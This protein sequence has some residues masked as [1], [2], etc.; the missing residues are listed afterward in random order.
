MPP[1]EYDANELTLTGGSETQPPDDDSDQ[2]SE[3]AITTTE[4]VLHGD[5]LLSQLPSSE[6][7]PM[8]VFGEVQNVTDATSEDPSSGS[9]SASTGTSGASVPDVDDNISDATTA[10]LEEGGNTENTSFYD[11]E[12]TPV[13]PDEGVTQLFSEDP[14][15]Q[16]LNVTDTPIVTQEQTTYHPGLV[17]STSQATTAFDCISTTTGEEAEVLLPE[18][19]PEDWMTI[20]TPN[21]P[22]ELISFPSLGNPVLA[23][24]LG[25]LLGQVSTL[26]LQIPKPPSICCGSFSEVLNGLGPYDISLPGIVEENS[27]LDLVDNDDLE[28]DQNRHMPDSAERKQEVVPFIKPNQ[29]W[30]PSA[31]F[32]LTV[33]SQRQAASDDFGEQLPSYTL[34]RIRRREPRSKT[35]EPN[36][37]DENVTEPA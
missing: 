37:Q 31:E 3:S 16:L 27:N 21:F 2:S 36:N 19:N 23:S 20:D 1:G 29:R 18:I 14:S 6:M 12:T 13:T 32:P 11:G 34:F 24:I 26:P 25:Q 15:G 35:E 22:T 9:T 4:A 28:P 5:A 30:Y 10:L 33:D 7:P 8:I 17:S